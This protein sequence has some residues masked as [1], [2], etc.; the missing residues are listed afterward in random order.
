[1]G[2]FKISSGQCQ[3]ADDCNYDDSESDSNKD[4]SNKSLNNAV[5]A[6]DANWADDEPEFDPN[7]DVNWIVVDNQSDEE[8]EDDEPDFDPEELAS[9]FS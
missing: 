6:S 5:K 1:M 2:I 3:N 8:S 7:A 4:E 9:Y